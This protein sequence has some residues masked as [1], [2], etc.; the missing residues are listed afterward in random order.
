MKAPKPKLQQN[1]KV[2]LKALGQ[3]LS[4][5]RYLGIGETETQPK[6]SKKRKS[7]NLRRRGRGLL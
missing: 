3:I 7:R 2:K 4:G 5:R 1:F 6:R